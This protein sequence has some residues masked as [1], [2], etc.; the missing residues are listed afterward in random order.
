MNPIKITWRSK[1]HLVLSVITLV[2]LLSSCMGDLEAP[3]FPP[4]A[5]VSI[6]QGSP[7]APAMDIFAN[8]NKVNRD[9]ML[10]SQ[11]LPYN[12]FFP[13]DRDFRFA[14]FNS[15]T[16]LLEKDFKLEADSVYSLF[17]VNESSN[18]DAVLVKDEWE[19]PKAE[20]AQLRLVHLSP[21]TENVSLE[22]S[23]ETTQTIENIAFKGASEFIE[24]PKGTTTLVI[25]SKTTNQ[26]LLTS[27]VLD[28]KGN[29]VYSVLIRGLKAESSGNKKL[30]LQILTNY[31]NY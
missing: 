19:E 5:Y 2:T 7:D 13:G 11:A 17:V 29:R 21:D 16:S 24:I 28:L 26:T 18:L 14:S 6:Y 23:Q 4:T 10:F 30:D 31:I 9:P 27:D 20:S 3:D 15:A 8:Q 12:A 22:I 25:K 1:F